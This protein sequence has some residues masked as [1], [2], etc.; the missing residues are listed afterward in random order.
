MGAVI[1]LFLIFDFF[2]LHLY[3]DPIRPLHLDRTYLFTMQ[4][5]FLFYI[6]VSFVLVMCMPFVLTLSNFLLFSLEWDGW[7][8]CI[9]GG[10]FSFWEREVEGGGIL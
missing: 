6:S 8:S 10:F 1:S 7:L 4:S 9:E 2:V 3:A 5:L